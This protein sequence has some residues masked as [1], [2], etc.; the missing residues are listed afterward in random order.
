MNITINL[1]TL[2]NPTDK[3]DSRKINSGSFYVGKNTPNQPNLPGDTIAKAQKKSMK[4]ILDQFRTDSATDQDLKDRA[5]HRE[6]LK[7]QIVAD[8]R[9]IKTIDDSIAS[10]KEQFG[11]TDETAEDD[12]PEE[13]KQIISDL[14]ARKAVYQDELDPQKPNNLYSLDRQEQYMISEIKQELLK[15]HDMVDTQKEAEEIIINALEQAIK[16]LV[17]EGREHIENSMEETKEEA[18][19][20]KSE[21]SRTEEEL[22]SADHEQEKA[23]E[24]LKKYIEEK[25]VIDEDAIGLVVDEK[26]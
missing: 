13:Y 20:K 11:I 3:G 16:E 24:E 9:E 8:L 21:E 19:E 25:H 2:V 17:E 14:E 15:Y 23:Q 12:Y 7:Q 10:Y 4:K 6:E 18:L 26:M 1:N 5:A 22:L